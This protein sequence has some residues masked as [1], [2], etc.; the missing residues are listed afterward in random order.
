MARHREVGLLPAFTLISYII[1]LWLL[2]N[3]GMFLIV[4]KI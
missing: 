1:R 4:V 2:V 3:A